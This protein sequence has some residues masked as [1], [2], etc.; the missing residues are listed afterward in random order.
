MTKKLH[1]H[2]NTANDWLQPQ[3]RIWGVTNEGLHHEVRLQAQTAARATDL[4]AGH[5]EANYRLA[6]SPTW[7]GRKWA[8]RRMPG[9]TI[10]MYVARSLGPLRLAFLTHMLGQTW[11][12]QI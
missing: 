1:N 8:G 3:S 5:S 12:H 9:D 2:V 4:S 11:L 10:E 6:G 7:V